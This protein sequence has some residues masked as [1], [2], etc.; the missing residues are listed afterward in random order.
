MGERKQCSG[1]ALWTVAAGLSFVV[2]AAAGGNHPEPRHYDRRAELPQV[3]TEPSPDELS[4]LASFAAAHPNVRYELNRQTG[5]IR[6]L[7]PTVG[8][9][10]EAAPDL[11][12]AEVA[13]RFLAEFVEMLGL[14]PKDLEGME[15]TD[16]VFSRNT[17]ITH[18]YFRQRLGGVPVYNGQLQVHVSREGRVLLVNNDFLPDLEESV[19]ASEPQIGAAQAIEAAAL[20]LGLETR[21][22]LRE[23]AVYTDAQQIRRF[24]APDLSLEPIEAR[25]FYLLVGSEARLVWNFQIWTVDHD[26]V[27]DLTVDALDGS[28]WTRYDW[29]ADAE[30]KVYPPPV[31]S[32]LHTTPPPPADARVTVTDPWH[33]T[34]SPY[35]WHDTNGVAGPEYTITRGNNVHAW[36]DSD[37]NNTEPPPAGETE[38][39]AMLSCVFPLDLTQEPSA[40]RPAAVANL[41]YWNNILHDIEYLYGFDE[42]AGN[43]QDNTYGRGGTGNDRVRALAQSGAGTCNAN[44][45]TPADGSPGRMRMYICNHDSN[46]ATPNRDGDLDNLVIVHEYGHGISNRL[47]GGPS[48]VSCLGNQQQPGEGLSDWW[49]LVYTHEPGDAG[50]DVRV[51]GV[52]LIGSGIRPQPYSTDPSVNTY[53]YQ[54]IGSGVSVPHGVGSVWAQAYWEAYWRLVDDHGFEPNLWNA[55]STAGNIRAKHYINEGLKLTACSPTF[56]NVR[57]GILAAAN[58]LYGG[59]DVCRL[60]EAFAAFGLGVDATTVGPNS[61]SATNGFQVPVACSFGSA[62]NDARICA[63]AVHNQNVL[64]GPAFTSPPVTLAVSG[65]PTGTTVSY[66]E[67]P[68]AGPLPKN[69]TITIGNTGSVPQG[70]YTID[71]QMAAGAQNYT[72]SFVLTVDAAAPVAPT[73]TAPTNATSG[74]PV[75]P[76]L[77]WSSVAEAVSYLIEIDDAPD[78]ASPVYS[79]TVTATSHVP[80]SNLPAGVVLHWRV[81]PQNAC[82]NGSPSAVWTFAT[83]AG[84][85]CN[86]GGPL[87][88]P[89]SGPASAYP[90][91]AT[92]TGSPVNPSSVKLVLNGLTHTYP[93][94]LD[95]LLVGPGGQTLVVLSDVGGGGDVVNLS[96]VL[97]DDAAA[98]PPDSGPLSAGSYR[99]SNVGGGDTFPAPAPAGPH[100]NPAPAGSATLLSTFGTGDPN[101]TWSLYLVDD[102]SSDSGTLA[103]WCLEL[104][105]SMPFMD[106]FETGNTS[107]WSSTV[108]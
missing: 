64:V 94:D 52:Y 83:S 106:G 44:F 57:D 82:G 11:P 54:T 20:Q 28:I 39:G 40:Y 23:L 73:L 84:Q 1:V 102:A 48:N 26:H 87:T 100:G 7:A 27:Y 101:G 67:N 46:P 70:A 80:T 61:L 5:A 45:L 49:G 37:G 68:V 47:V 8:F 105:V 21:A 36:E 9:L 14:S 96:L 2:S 15:V 81:T 89:D 56:L 65:H 92:V 31:E 108:P 30:Y 25:L 98:L 3:E 91:T 104:P 90:S 71:V 107:R 88:I 35:G 79:A 63:G 12:P 43:F 38:C 6:T 33:L 69:V 59:E 17:G 97:D 16:Q 51:V 13:S 32:P 78:F 24:L 76:T 42:P 50:T 77:A 93:D 72:D 66:S 86:A 60:W 41:F 34:G 99:P 103:G 19:N 74:H 29:V 62:G 85:F 22:Q 58:T 53:T 10:T 18:L 4:R 95:F 55:A 75:K